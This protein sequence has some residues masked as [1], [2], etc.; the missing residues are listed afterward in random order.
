MDIAGGKTLEPTKPKIVATRKK[1]LKPPPIPI[2][3]LLRLNQLEARKHI[4]EIANIVINKPRFNSKSCVIV[5]PIVPLFNIARQD[6]LTTVVKKNIK[7]N[8]PAKKVICVNV[9]VF[10]FVGVDKINAI[11]PAST[12][13]AIKLFAT[14]IV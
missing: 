6:T 4:P 7:N 3:C 2:E 13:P 10:L 1:M 11:E 14:I 9:T 8:E 5:S 12:C